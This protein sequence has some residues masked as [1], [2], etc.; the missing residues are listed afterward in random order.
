MLNAKCTVVAFAVIAVSLSGCVSKGNATVRF[1]S[2]PTGATL[3]DTSFGYMGKTPLTYQYSWEYQTKNQRAWAG[4]MRSTSESRQT[5]VT[6]SKT[7]YEPQTFAVTLY[8]DSHKTVEFL[9]EE[10]PKG[11]AWQTQIELGTEPAGCHVTIN[12]VY[13]GDSPLRIPLKWN[14]MGK[15]SAEL[16]VSK[17]GYHEIVRQVSPSEKKI[18]LTLQPHVSAPR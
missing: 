11:A 18:F 1:V 8:P 14:T 16:R 10:S 17:S 13:V 4:T 3:T 15:T 6:A 9:L 5:V 12:G 7:G 2:E